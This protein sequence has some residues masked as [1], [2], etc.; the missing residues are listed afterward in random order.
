MVWWTPSSCVKSEFFRG[1][2]SY[3]DD[4]V[5]LM[6]LDP[7]P[8]ITCVEAGRDDKDDGA[9]RIDTPVVLVVV[10]ASV[11]N[12]FLVFVLV[13]VTVPLVSLPV[14]VPF[15]AIALVAVVLRLDLCFDVGV[16]LLVSRRVTNH[17]ALI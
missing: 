14:T 7:L 17:V 1:S 9:R 16:D 13:L 3:P 8:S 12:I 15:D 5:W 11:D 6:L 4:V 2:C 10:L